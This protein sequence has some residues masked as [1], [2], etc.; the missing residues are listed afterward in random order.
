MST[1]HS[2]ILGI[3][4]VTSILTISGGSCQKHYNKLRHQAY[5]ECIK[6]HNFPLQCG[7]STRTQ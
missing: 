3:T 1:E 2:W 7:I 4:I 5:T 6:E